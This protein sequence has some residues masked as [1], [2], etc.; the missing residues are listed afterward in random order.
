[1]KIAW[2]ASI[3]FILGNPREDDFW[4]VYFLSES[5][6]LFIALKHEHMQMKKQNLRD[7]IKTAPPSPQK[8]NK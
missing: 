7:K 3:I 4:I 1:M 5:W 6:K 8:I 2:T